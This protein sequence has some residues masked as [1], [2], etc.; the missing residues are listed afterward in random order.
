MSVQ[1]KKHVVVAGENMDLAN[2][3]AEKDK[4]SLIVR[5]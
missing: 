3:K 2:F 4:C 5:R 1:F